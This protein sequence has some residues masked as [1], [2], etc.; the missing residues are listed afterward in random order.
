MTVPANASPSVVA[1]LIEGSVVRMDAV[2]EDVRSRIGW[3]A[4][5]GRQP[6]V[7]V[8]RGMPAKFAPDVY[9]RANRWRDNSTG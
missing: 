2:H 1:T 5:R 6:S 3:Y 9:D 4:A 8:I 7:Q